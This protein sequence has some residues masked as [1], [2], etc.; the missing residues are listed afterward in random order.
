[1]FLGSENW[2]AAK[3]F[4]KRFTTYDSLFQICASAWSP[5]F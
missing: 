2:N 3:C 5:V 1:M 4:G